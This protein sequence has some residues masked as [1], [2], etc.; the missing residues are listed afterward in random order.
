MMTVRML[1]RP[2]ACSLSLWAM[3][4]EASIRTTVSPRSR[5]PTREGGIRPCRTSTN[6]HTCARMLA[7]A[8]RSRCAGPISLNARHSVGSRAT[9]PNTSPDPAA[10]PDP[11]APSH[12]QRSSPPYQPPPTRSCTGQTSP[13]Q[14]L[15]QRSG[16]TQPISDQ[17]HCGRPRMR[18]HPLPAHLHRQ[19]LRPRCR[20]HLKSAPIR[21]GHEDLDTLILPGQEHFPSNTHSHKDRREF[22]GSSVV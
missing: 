10:W 13:P 14:R 12:H 5:S 15:G 7:R 18:D 22:P 6:P 11:T 1:K 4:T 20:L 9:G 17:P 16:Q 3:R 21:A 8:I 2:A 19:I